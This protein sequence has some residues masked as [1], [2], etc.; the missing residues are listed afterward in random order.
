MNAFCPN[1]DFIVWRRTPLGICQ[2]TRLRCRSWQ[3]PYCAA[4]NR[5]MWR[6]HLKKR[7]GKLGG[8]WWFVT[9]TA[10]SWNQTVAKSL[11]TLRHGIDLLFK[12]VRRVWGKIE[13]I[14][15][16]ETHQTGAFHAHLVVSGL[17]VRV[18]Y[19][20][21]RSGAAAFTPA[22]KR[23]EHVWSLKTWFKKTANAIH[24]GYMVDVKKCQSV[25][26]VVNYVAKYMTKSAQM[27]DVKGLRRIQTS[28]GIGAANPRHEARGWQAVKYV[29]A[30]DAAGMPVYDLNLKQTINPSYW[31]NNYTYP[32]SA[33]A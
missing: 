20:R 30:A 17:S 33:Q 2:V 32:P 1:F 29:Y 25:M 26:H 5:K 11:A 12:R 10:A 8:D 15:V 13:Y 23:G 22:D 27:F 24:I 18:A 21:A 4:E 16:Y 7:I 31:R 14:R 9:L 28:Q 3:C 19:R 6:S